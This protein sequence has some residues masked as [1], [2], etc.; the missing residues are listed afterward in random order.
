MVAAVVYMK[1]VAR[2]LAEE[3]SYEGRLSL[4]PL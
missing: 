4:D 3:Y 1:L 2:G